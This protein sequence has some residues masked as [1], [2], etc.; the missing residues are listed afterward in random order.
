MPCLKLSIFKVFFCHPS[1]W[2][3]HISIPG[4]SY[5]HKTHSPHVSSFVD[6]CYVDVVVLQTTGQQ[7][8]AMDQPSPPAYFFQIKF[9][10][11]PAAPTC[12]HTVWHFTL[13]QQQLLQRL[14]GLQSQKYL[15]SGC[16]QKKICQPSCT[17][18]ETFVSGPFCQWSI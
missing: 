10:W 3:P 11:N 18:F 12:L 8:I 5:F 16:L 9:Y 14:Y 1:L 15:L 17:L 2:V 6:L 4:Y 13:Q 7:T